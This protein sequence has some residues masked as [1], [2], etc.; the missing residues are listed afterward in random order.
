MNVVLFSHEYPPFLFGGVGTFVKDLA[1]GLSKEGFDV[2]VVSGEPV[3]WRLNEGQTVENDANVSIIRLKYPNVIPRHVAFQI[4]NSNKC[5]QLMKELKP[6][7]IHG[8]SGS[9][10]PAI[11]S[12]KKISPVVVT[13]HG[14]PTVQKNLSFNSLNNGGT[15]GDFFTNGLG[16]PSWLFGYKREHQAAN[17]C[18]A[19][20]QSLMNQLRVELSDDA[21]KLCYIRNGIDLKMLDSLSPL[22]SSEPP[23][24]TIIYGG[25]LFWN[26]GVM[27][28]VTLAYLLEKKYGVPL[29]VI[30]YGSGPMLD[31]IIQMKNKHGLHNL[32]LRSFTN[33]SDFLV[34]LLNSMYVILPSYY[35]G[36]P[37]L[38][39]EGMCLGK[40]PIM[41]NLPFSRE[42]TNNGCYGILANSVKDMAQKIVD[43]YSTRAILKVDPEIMEFARNNYSIEKTA[44]SYAKLYKKLLN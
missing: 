10:F 15:F 2:T 42:F 37:M 38:L 17:A 22:S 19:V 1:H 14:S 34:N 26:K 27:N 31:K 23:E 44:L 11:F 16:F 3:P 33:R 20:S 28:L 41:F 29:K 5:L 21:S 12:L 25:R 35:E 4:F 9:T 40:T 13:F 32:E 30:I 39:L 8:Q 7:I 6:D 36:S 18:V 24:P 43:D